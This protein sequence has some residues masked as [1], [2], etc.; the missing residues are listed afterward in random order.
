MKKLLTLMTGLALMTACSS[1]Q[2]RDAVVSDA[3]PAESLQMRIDTLR[4]HGYM[5]AHQDDPF[6]GINWMWE[7]G[8]SDTYELVGDYPGV[9]GFDLG[10]IEVGDLGNL[11]HVPFSWIREEAIKHVE[12]G[13]I[14]TFSW[15]PRNP[16]T[17]GNSW[18]VTDSTT[19]RNILPGGEQHEKFVGWMDAV[20]A[21]LRTIT[22]EDGTPIPFILRPWHEYN[23]SWFWWGQKN[24]TDEQFLSLWV[25]FQ[26]YVNAAL[27]T[28]IVWAF[29]PNLQGNWTE[30]EFLKRY[31]G[32]DRVFLI[33][34]DAYQWG[35]EEDFK[36]QLAADLDF[37]NGF[38][39]KN[40]K[41]IALTEC[42]YQNSPDPT[43]WTHVLKP[44]MDRYPI[45][46]FLPWRN[47][48]KEHFGASKGLST[49]DDFINL[50]KAENT[51]FLNDIK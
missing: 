43:W 20:V 11:D 33:G 47:W 27:P 50:Y 37:L 21:F 35:T 4:K 22:Y 41:P 3:S 15:H 40:G 44:I 17:G 6:Y 13:G 9:M 51:L 1:N 8:R 34:E 23:G 45:S 19:V 26:D 2:Q 32:N 5:Y 25:M 30:E 12:R 16:R 29:S 42:G 14:I 49:A 28:N 48:Y 18:D 38:A 31:P 36:K 39:T 46:Y 24:C 7:R 10:G